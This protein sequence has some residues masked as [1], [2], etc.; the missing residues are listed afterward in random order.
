M[1]MGWR[2]TTRIGGRVERRTFAELADALD[3]LE[4]ECRAIA[5]SSRRS[6]VTVAKRTYEPI[7][8]VQAR[9]ELRGPQG[10][11]GG[12]DVRGDGSVEAFT[13]RVRRRLVQ[14]R[15]REDAYA[16]LRRELSD[17]VGP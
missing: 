5:T 13:G 6:E 10:V 2:L 11:S 4:T 14:Q 3:E 8:Q 16:A 17:S 7:V 1:R 15:K 9:C 12:I